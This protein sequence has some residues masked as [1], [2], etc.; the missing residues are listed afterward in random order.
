M[1]SQSGDK[2]TEKKVT[3]ELANKKKHT[4]LIDDSSLIVLDNNL[5]REWFLTLARDDTCN[6][7]RLIREEPRLARVR[8]F[9]NGK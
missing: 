7:K 6:I 1:H 9:G 8:D 5:L 3:P 2:L 4:G